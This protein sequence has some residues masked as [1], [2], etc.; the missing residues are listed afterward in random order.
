MTVNC[1]KKG[2]RNKACDLRALFSAER[3]TFASSSL[4]SSNGNL[5]CESVE[6]GSLDGARGNIL[7]VLVSNDKKE[8][9]FRIIK[10]KFC[11]DK[12]SNNTTAEIWKALGSCR[13]DKIERS[14]EERKSI[15]IQSSNSI[16]NFASAMTFFISQK[17]NEK[18]ERIS[19][20]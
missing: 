10:K 9:K 13:G 14:G 17:K 7:P 4:P 20:F 12:I 15:K 8:H 16:F 19:N 18:E 5:I 1:L 11:Q 2:S 3:L 6:K